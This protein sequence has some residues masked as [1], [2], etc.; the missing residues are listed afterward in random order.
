MESRSHPLL[1]QLSLLQAP[2]DQ[3]L[4]RCPLSQ[5][6]VIDLAPTLMQQLDCRLG[7]LQQGADRLYWSVE[8][9]GAE[10]ALH[11]EALCDSLWLQGPA[12]E[13]AYLRQ[14][15]AKEWQ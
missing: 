1:Q 12:E 4:W 2:A 13:I 7:Q 15:A 3:L 14:L 5:E 6:Q 9:E 10:L 8:F 11:F